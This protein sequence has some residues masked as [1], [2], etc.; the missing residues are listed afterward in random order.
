MTV[1]PGI[2]RKPAN[3]PIGSCVGPILSHGNAV[4]RK[5]IN[6][7]Q[8]HDRPKADGGL[9]VI[10]EYEERGAERDYAAMRGHAI[11]GGTHRM[12]AHAEGNIAAR[13]APC[14]AHRTRNVLGLFLFHWLEIALVLQC[15]VGGGI[16]IG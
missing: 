1:K 9:H 5:D 2:A 12:L 16:Q 11:H 3:W 15:R 10:G 8:A 13:I 14:A 7:P 6:H 4:V